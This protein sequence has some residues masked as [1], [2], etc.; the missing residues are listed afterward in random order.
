MSP[1]G[2]V[3]S[4]EGL[5]MKVGLVLG[6]DSDIPVMKKA[7]DLLN[8]VWNVKSFWLQPIA[9]QPKYGSLHLQH[10]TGA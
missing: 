10:R 6:S 1:L 7:F 2:F 8:L 5:V 9:H 4:E 3:F